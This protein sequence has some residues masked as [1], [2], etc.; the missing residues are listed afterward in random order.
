[1][2]QF[3]VDHFDRFIQ[4]G[5]GLLTTSVAWLL[6][7]S[8]ARQ[9]K[10]NEITSQLI[11]TFFGVESFK[12]RYEVLKIARKVALGDETDLQL[13]INDN[14][15]RYEVELPPA[16]QGGL[17]P[18]HS[19]L[20]FLYFFAEIAANYDMGLLDK[21]IIRKTFVS[22]Y[23]F[24]KPF[25][26]DVANFYTREAPR[27]LATP[28]WLEMLPKLDTLMGVQQDWWARRKAQGS[29]WTRKLRWTRK[30]Q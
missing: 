29:S 12:I 10:R 21:K 9:L 30:S 7:L 25:L 6:A 19:L 18:I 3:V 15:V 17:R 1:M 4:I 16:G 27:E 11:R 24:W 5:A 26:K 13:L 20:H 8:T 14:F 23:E 2:K 28:P 22:Q